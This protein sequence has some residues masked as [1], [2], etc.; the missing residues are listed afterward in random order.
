MPRLPREGT[1]L[2]CGYLS[3][4][5]FEPDDERVLIA[6]IEGALRRAAD[7][8]LAYVVLG[9]ST[10]C[11]SSLV[12]KRWFKHRAYESVLYAA[13][14]PDGEAMARSLDGRPSNPELALL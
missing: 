9:L 5:A 3:H 11:S 6:L 1:Q 10:A 14:W 8:R 13:F 7:K 12:V 2:Q 4:L